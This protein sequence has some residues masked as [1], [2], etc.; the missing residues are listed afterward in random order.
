MDLFRSHVLVC[1]GAG[2][3]SSGC[4][5]VKTAL[6]DAVERLGLQQ[7]VKVVV[8]GCMGPCDLG[9]MMIIYPEGVLYQ[10]LKPADADRIAEEH[11]LKGR[12]VRDLLYTEP[13]TGAAVPAFQEMGFFNRQTR[14]ALR[15]TGRINP[16]VIEEYIASDGYSA[17]GKVLTKMT[18]EEVIDTVKRSGLRGR[19]GGGFPTGLK[20]E[21]CAKAKGNPKY[22]VCNAD[23]GDP[24]AFMD[25][26]VLEGDPHSVLE[27]MTIAG[28][29]IGAHQG[30]IY[31][32][33]EYPLAIKHLTHA[34]GQAREQGL[35][36]NDIFG[37]GFDF[38]IEIRVGAGAF[39]CGEETALLASIEGRRGEPRPRPP[40][41]AN[42]GLWG[43]PTL[44]NNVE[45]YANI[46]PIIL[47]GAEWFASIGT[48]R[49]KGTK[50]FALAGKIRNTGLVEVPMGTTLGEIIYDIG[51]GI[52]GG[53]KFKAAQT[54]G[55]SGGCI[56]KEYLNTPVDYDS[57][58]ELGTI[59][60]SG[61]LI[62][63]DEDT[64]MVDLAR[65]FLEFT[66]DE[67]CGKC[68]PCRI[69]TKRMLEILT[70]I[71]RGQGREGDVERLIKLGQWIKETALCGLGQTA[72]NPVLTTIRYF[73]EEYDA[74]IRDHKCPASVCASLF[75][76]PCQNAC[77]ASVD[78]PRYISLIRQ[79][80]YSDAVTVIRDKNP[81]PSICGRVCT[82]PCELKCRRAQIDEPVAICAL[83]R[84]AADY[85]MKRPPMAPPV[86]RNNPAASNVAIIG[87]GPCGLSAA[88]YLARLGHK[89]VVFDAL[90]VAGGMLAV[91]IPEYRLPKRVL[92]AEIETIK[93]LGVDIRLNTRIG[94]DISLEDLKKQGF[95]AIF[96]AIG[97]HLGQKLGAP[98]EDLEGVVNAI[99]FLRE[100]NLGQRTG[101]PRR[102]A[103]IGGGNAA[104][105]AAR[106][107]LRLGAKEVHILYR[108]TREEMPAEPYEVMEAEKEGIRIHFLTAPSR[109]LGK[110]GKVT[111]M[112]CIRMVLGEFDRTG[113]RRPVPVVGSEFII[114]VDLI[115]PAIS[116][117]P[118]ISFVPRDSGIET[119]RWSTILANPKTFATGADGIFA[120]G[121]C[122]TGPDTVIGAIGQGRCAAMEIDKYLGGDGVIET[123]PDLGRELAGEIIETEMPR[124]KVESLDISA[125]YPGFREVELGFT[126]A[127]ALQE[128]MRCLRCDIKD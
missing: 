114:D 32:R 121:D 95:K 111:N 86:K 77:P 11:L 9:P 20:W 65:F 35:L 120:G 82:H 128:A 18:P 119:T 66:Q 27:A 85:E 31:V 13:V 24:G 56:P 69:G 63:M 87:A 67:S 54:G 26:S 74:H 1:G 91:G 15:N 94:K 28:Y 101:V 78:V 40:F 25:R 44:I 45:T 106:T 36:G 68:A 61:G 109:I 112:E 90:P 127:A 16:L 97:A 103:V 105:D 53:K 92:E 48:E 37:T 99:D 8:T 118:D 33:A 80:R 42:E 126:E 43:C 125:R 75:E 116:Q 5:G 98:G 59:M 70:R 23:E 110:A 14:V 38:D 30:Y 17:L 19:G 100:V 88:Y 117:Q 107:A 64:C 113:R 60:G 46:P 123:H 4:E 122:V 72:P 84:F 89:V 58:K 50:V 6:L 102:V 22:V 2:C 104:I 62:V 3:L 12:I 34:I 41:P 83:K 52:P 47:N 29:A 10:R 79:K 76:S 55:P 51:G 115:I 96:I 108:R 57:L 71:T 49:S 73:R 39:V 21:F 7:E 93:A 124:Q 81:F